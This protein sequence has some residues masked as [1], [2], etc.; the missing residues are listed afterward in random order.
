M[1]TRAWGYAAA[2]LATAIWSGNVI[3]AR[4]VAG[5]IPPMQL[6]FWRWVVALACILP[7]AL[8]VLRQDMRAM[9][10]H[11]GYMTLVALFGVT[12]MN[13][14]IYK[15]G[16]TTTSLNMGLIMP[17]APVV[18]ILLARVMHG[19]RITARRMAGVIMVLAGIVFLLTRG[20]LD[21]LLAVR[22][23][24]GDLWVL[25]GMAAFALYSLLVRHLP[26]GVGAL[27]FNTL[28]FAWGLVL[29]LPI[30][31]WEMWAYPAPQ[32]TA[33]VW[34]SVLYTSLGCSC[35]AYML[36]TWAVTSIGPVNA[37]LVYYS[38]PLFVAVEGVVLLG[39]RVTVAH[40]LGGGLIV[41]G[42]VLATR[43]VATAPP[44][45]RTTRNTERT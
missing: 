38:F 26:P 9:R 44:E 12:L 19:E 15:A 20:S 27:G 34:G 36:W 18:I 31:A 10:G 23:T 6:N 42:I 37:G 5:H 16:Q 21:N 7:F 33:A 41:V 32:W 40:A 28:M 29:S 11:W 35:A 2:L 22:F 30:L 17:A 25:G 24:S 3:V 8:R 43:P 14:L 4:G 13:T 45:Q 1:R 39:E